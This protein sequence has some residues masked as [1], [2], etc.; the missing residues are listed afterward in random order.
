MKRILVTASA[1]CFLLSAQAQ[2][3]YDYLKAADDYY[4]KADYYSA[5]QYYEKY[6]SSNGIIKNGEFDPYVVRASLNN[7]GQKELSSKEQ[8][9]YNL[10][11][12]YRQL[13]YYVKAE[14]F[15]QEAAAFDD[16]KFPLA[17][18]HY[19]TTLRALGKFE[20]AEKAF[21]QF[22]EVYKNNDKYTEA[23]NREIANLQYIQVQMKKKDLRQ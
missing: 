16:T 6:L 11:E 22:L 21:R 20:E 15:Y 5:A 4:R 2:F 13:N 23:A 12:S 19:A 10:A 17:D 1:I 7:K 18:Y 9:I 8:A 14:P 3:T